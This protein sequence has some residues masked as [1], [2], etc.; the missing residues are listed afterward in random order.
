MDSSKI[1][2]VIIVVSAA[3]FSVYLGVAAATA[4]LEAIAW[5]LGLAGLIAVLAMGK[6]IWVFIPIGAVLEG[7]INAIPGSPQ[8]WWLATVI[9]AGM[10]TLRFVMRSKDFIFR[11]TW[12]DFAILLQVVAVGQSWIR[13]P[14]GFSLFGGDSVGGKQNIIFMMASIG[15]V[16]MSVVK[17][18][19]VMVKRVVM[20]M[21]VFSVLGGLVYVLT[22]ASPN[23]AVAVLPFWSGA[24]YSTGVAAT[25]GVAAGLE[26]SRFVSAVLLSKALGRATICLYIPLSLL[27]PLHFFRFSAFMLALALAMVS[28][29]RSEM[30]MFAI[31][32]VVATLV[33][34]RP[35]DLVIA[36]F[37]GALLLCLL[38]FS[39]QVNKLPFGAQRILAALSIE[40]DAGAKDSGDDSSEWRF[41]MWREALRSDRYIKNKLL[42]DGLGYSAAEQRAT[43]AAMEGDQR[44]LGGMSSQEMMMVRGIFHG[45]HVETIR[46]TGIFGLALAL[47]G[48]GIFFRTALRM[49]NYYRGRPEWMYVLYLCIPFLIHPFYKMLI[50]GAYRADFPLVLVGAGMLKVLDNIRFM[51]AS[52]APA[53]QRILGKAAR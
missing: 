53:G 30:A 18:D 2:I 47:I 14:A 42:G 51:E 6:H 40:V 11:F 33:R 17:T 21:I 37:G 24:N 4:Q 19:L 22:E 13:N 41:E 16:L 5:V 31:L 1:K 12:M 43:D 15:Y 29:F 28:G 36:S 27:N 45:F 7:G 20:G 26:T 50:W 38:L 10:L 32:F 49:I 48:M 3:F 25:G 8:P 52:A 44:S 23:L 9:A 39:G 35:L 46:C 34:R